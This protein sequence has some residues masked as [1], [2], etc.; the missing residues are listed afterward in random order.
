MYKCAMLSVAQWLYQAI[1]KKKID[2]F[3]SIWVQDLTMPVQK[4]AEVWSV[5]DAKKYNIDDKRNAGWVNHELD[6]KIAKKKNRM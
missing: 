1:Q 3:F 4:L 5:K 6:Q 2:H